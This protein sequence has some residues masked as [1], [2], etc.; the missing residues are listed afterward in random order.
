MTQKRIKESELTDFPFPEDQMYGR[1][2]VRENF[3]RDAAYDI[4]QYRFW[5]RYFET[6]AISSFEWQGVPDEIPV[7]A[8]E[9][10]MLKFGWGAM[11]T[12]YDTGKYLFAQAAPSN[13]VDMY[14]NPNRIML[15]APNGMSWERH[16]S[17]WVRNG[18][19]PEDMTFEDGDAVMLYDNL[20]RVPLGE[21]IR[22]YARRLAEIDRIV[23]VNMGAQRTPFIIKGP[24]GSKMNRKSLIKHLEHNDQY[25]EVNDAGNF[26]NSIDVLQTA[27]PYIAKDL[28]EDKKKILNEA[29][30][31]FGID[32]TDTEKKERMI[33]AEATS[34]NEQIMVCRRSRLEMR[35]TF[36]EQVNKKWGLDMTVEWGVKHQSEAN[37]NGWSMDMHDHR[38]ELEEGGR[39]D[40]GI[41]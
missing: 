16:C 19:G 39:R 36:C 26:D 2:W 23:E 32:N 24:A 20:L 25:I 33:D 40:D 12:D 35:R 30:T 27:A 21:V 28:L 38:A 14:Y 7:R 34:N 10:I 4:R 6:L 8:I 31:F 1:G 5:V 22:N 18:D 29:I 3:G 11:F 17:N 15:Y 9:Y 37:L 13:N 41:V